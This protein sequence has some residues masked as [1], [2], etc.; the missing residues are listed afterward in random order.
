MNCAQGKSEGDTRANRHISHE[1]A[2]SCVDALIQAQGRPRARPL[3]H[4]CTELQRSQESSA[5]VTRPVE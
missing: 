5:Q 4:H 2:E 1:Q 3:L